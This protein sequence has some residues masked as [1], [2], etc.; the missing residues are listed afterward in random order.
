MFDIEFIVPYEE[1]VNVVK[2]AFEEFS[3]RDQINLH[4]KR[5]ELEEAKQHRFFGEAIIARGLTA[6]YIKNLGQDTPLIEL[7]IVGYDVIKA[8]SQGLK[9]YNPTHIAFIGTHDMI[10][11]AETLELY[12]QCKISVLPIEHHDDA[13]S[14]IE[15]ARASG[16]DLFIGGNQ[17]Y[18]AAVQAGFHAVRIQSGKEGVRQALNESLRAAQ[19]R[20]QER[21]RAERFR[22]LVENVHQ[23]IVS[24][25]R[26]GRIITINGDAKRLLKISTNFCIGRLASD[27]IPNIDFS[28]LLKLTEPSF[29]EVISVNGDSLTLNRIPIKVQDEVVSH[30]ITFQPV[31]HI[32]EIESRIRKNAHKKGLVARYK[33]NDIIGDSNL[34]KKTLTLAKNYSRVNANILI[35]GETGSGKELFAQ[36]IHNASIRK[37]GPFVAINCAALP[38]SLLES[39]LFGY[40]EGAFTGAVKSGKAGLFELAHGGT[41][42]L[43]EISEISPFLQGRLLRVLEEREIMRIGHDEVIPVDIRIIS[44]SN[45]DLHEQVA[46]GQ[47]REDLLYRLDVLR[48]HIPPVRDR[49]NDIRLLVEHLL[50]R[51]D[52]QIRGSARKIEDE[53]WPFLLSR[54][55]EG[56]VRHIRNFCE[57]LSVI[58][59]DTRIQATEVEQAYGVDSGRDDSSLQ[60]ARENLAENKSDPWENVHDQERAT[61]LKCLQ[62]C[63]HN[64]TEAARLLG[65]DRSTLWRRMKKLNLD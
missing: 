25:N 28:G 58:A 29:G 22:T 20:Q 65:I 19:I 4:I 37:N 1:L 35:V 60:N 16:A 46:V 55:W 44:A 30:L 38:E 18:R 6:S 21:E 59:Q 13:D 24:V 23:G 33:F 61:I 45:K 31:T 7:P 27:I 62:D 36:S 10:Y 42:F 15:T 14:V 48:L 5:M 8:I 26:W 50:A 43:D 34:I 63:G 2:L 3:H 9:T 57:R 39:E 12:F 56:N 11:G 17:V 47:F 53:C 49:R 52:H 41:I 51:F 64:R 54:K 40:V 32:Q